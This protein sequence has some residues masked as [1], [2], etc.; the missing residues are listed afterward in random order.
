MSNFSENT[1][2]KNTTDT[3]AFKESA[4]IV[5]STFI[6]IIGFF[7]SAA[8]LLVSFFLFL[9]SPYMG[10]GFLSYLFM[11]SPIL[12]I[13]ALAIL[14]SARLFYKNRSK[15]LEQTPENVSTSIATNK[16]PSEKK[17]SNYW[18]IFLLLVGVGILGCM[19]LFAVLLFIPI[20]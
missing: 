3:A 19:T 6:Y 7:A 17:S 2:V 18:A 12:V 13:F 1:E 14:I 15:T 16:S 9:I 11:F 20:Q 8:I 5:G 4:K 10:G